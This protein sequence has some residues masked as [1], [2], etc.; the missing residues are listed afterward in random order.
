L[1]GLNSLYSLHNAFKGSGSDLARTSATLGT[2][3][4]VNSTLP[5]LFASGPSAP[6][7]AG[8]N[9]FLNGSGTGANGAFTGL[10]AGNVPGA[11]PALGLIISIK[12]GDPIGTLSGA[13]GLINPSLLTGPVGWILT[14]ISIL[15]TLM[16][17]PP[18]AWGVAKVI[19]DQNGQL[20]IDTQ[21]E[22]F[23]TQ[24][25][26]Q[27]M[28]GTLDYLNGML[29]Q[30]KAENPNAQ[31]GLVPQRLA[32]ITW[33]EARQSDAGYAI[34]DIDPVTGQQR[35]PYLRWDDT[36]TP[37]SSRPDL[38]QPDPADPL[39]RQSMNERLIRSGLEREAI[40][41]LWEVR[42]AQVQQ[43]AI[44]PDAR[45]D[46]YEFDSWLRS[47]YAGQ[48]AK[49]LNKHPSEA[50]EAANDVGWRVVA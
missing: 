45:N 24:R 2:L 13:I 29:T 16:D 39:I 49:T 31:W 8:L 30:L 46:Y 20:K 34:N 42:T 35:Y 21:G 25:V 18:E 10:G 47:E 9:S 50:L 44:K 5:S 33:R 17:E 40:A 26:Q 22:A 41:P 3:N 27:Q 6:L 7:S 43:E 37:F 4:Y 1:Q 11:L 36:G 12:N 19:F 48:G 15:K 38:W 14:G 32:S 23:G 28:Q